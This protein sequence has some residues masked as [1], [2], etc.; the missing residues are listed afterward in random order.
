MPV[1]AHRAQ[2]PEGAIL[3]DADEETDQ[4]A[5]VYSRGEN[6]PVVTISRI[7]EKL[8]MVLADGIAVAIVAS[9]D[10]NRLT[11]QDVLLVERF[12]SLG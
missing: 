6:P 9:H 10:G 5:V 11:P 7:S 12:V 2:A 3:P 4:I 8:Q 1:S